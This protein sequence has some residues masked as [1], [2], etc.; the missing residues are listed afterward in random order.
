MIRDR[1]KFSSEEVPERAGEW[2]V[3]TQ[4]EAMELEEKIRA[5]IDTL[6]E[7]CREIFELNRFEGLK[8][9][10]IATQLDISVKTVENQMTK[11]LKLLREQLGKYLSIL[12]W[13]MLFT[14]N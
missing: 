14:L 9:S 8:Y 12:L 4:L 10:E 13:L 5:A 11:A 6:P 7:R 1:K 2:D 3:S